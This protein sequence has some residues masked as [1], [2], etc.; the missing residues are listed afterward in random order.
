MATQTLLDLRERVRAWSN[1]KDLSD[2]LLNDFI[3]IAQARL[4]RLLR[5]PPLE[6]DA[7]LTPDAN[8]TVRIPR[9]FLEMIAIWYTDA[10]GNRVSLDRKDIAYLNQHSSQEEGCPLF[11]ARQGFTLYLSP[12]PESVTAD[13]LELYYYATVQPLTQDEDAN[14]FTEDAPEVL[15]YGALTELSLYLRDEIGAGQWEAKFQN[16]S[17][18][19]QNIENNAMWSGGTLAING[20]Q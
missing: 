5:I 16:H 14:W 1:R 7:T 8:G 17:Q 20:T 4:N 11:F 2:D 6:A 9:E 19:I 3:N 13:S 10:Q 18:E 12:I 15:L